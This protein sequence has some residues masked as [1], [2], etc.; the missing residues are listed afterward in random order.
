MSWPDFHDSDTFVVTGFFKAL[1]NYLLLPCL[2]RKDAAHFGC[3]RDDW[4]LLWIQHTCDSTLSCH[5]ERWAEWPE[6]SRGIWQSNAILS[7]RCFDCGP[8][9]WLGR[10]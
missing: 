10:H 2:I 6:D 3:T 1:F 5:G 8:A 7:I 9:G 4:F